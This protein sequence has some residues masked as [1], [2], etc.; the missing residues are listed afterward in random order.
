[1]LDAVRRARSAQVDV[2]AVTNEPDSPLEELATVTLQCEAGIE[3]VV[4]ATKS[5]TAQ[6][7]LLHAIAMRNV[8]VD[9]L[10]SCVRTVMSIDLSPLAADEQPS[11]IVCGGFAGQWVADEVALKFTEMAGTL[12]TSECVVEHF[13]G[14]RAADADIIGFIDP[15]DPNCL[16]SRD[17]AM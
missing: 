10:V 4:A 11:A 13:H 1:M 8:P 9:E 2:V 14:P 16:E 7:M 15:D 17:N 5:V 3:R 12:V 6:M